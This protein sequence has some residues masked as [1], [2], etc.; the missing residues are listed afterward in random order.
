MENLIPQSVFEDLI[1]QLSYGLIEDKI[2][3][4]IPFDYN[5]YDFD[6]DIWEKVLKPKTIEEF[7]NV[8]KEKIGDKPYKIKEIFNAKIINDVQKEIFSIDFIIS[9]K[10]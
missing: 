5:F 7:K 10:K 6:E 9:Y 4:Q 2:N 3:I 8:I 1:E